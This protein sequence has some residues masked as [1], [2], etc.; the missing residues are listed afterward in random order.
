MSKIKNGGFPPPNGND[1]QFNSKPEYDVVGFDENGTTVYYLCF[2]NTFI[3]KK[4]PIAY[5]TYEEA[6]RDCIALNLRYN[7]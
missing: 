6:E 5:A 1:D 2:K 7:Y 4:P 3:K